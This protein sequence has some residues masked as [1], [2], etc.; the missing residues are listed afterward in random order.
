MAA[1][2]HL[3]SE[4]N[5]VKQMST[6]FL[7]LIFSTFTAL[8]ANTSLAQSPAA[9]TPTSP[10]T[11]QISTDPATQ[12]PPA[13]V[14]EEGK[15]PTGEEDTKPTR[16]FVSALVHNLGDDVKHIPRRNSLYWLGGGAAL[17]L[18]VHPE[19]RKINARLVN[20]SSDKLWVPG[21]IIG[22]TYLILGAAGATYI[23]GRS[24]DYHRTQHLGMDIIEASILS[25]GLV[26]GMK[27][28]AR[29]PRPTQVG[30]GTQSKT[31]SFPSGHAAITFAAATVFQQHMGYKAAIPTYLV[32]SYVA[33]SRLHDNR[34][35]ASDVLFG[36]A[37][38]IVVG[39]SVTWHGR[40]FY[41][42]P[43]L[44]PGG[45]GIQLMAVR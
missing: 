40:N 21:H 26:E 17:A 28:I 9:S 38:G 27:V 24:T 4:G 2:G 36:A 1:S 44:V 25:E 33:M 13:A 35:Y 8:F 10:D 16:G 34:H 18:A 32:A 39:R 7:I 45:A 5:A 30:G 19:D 31:Y 43:M 6:S 15:K 12:K 22:N 42:S 14:G 41:A 37:T 23:F 29:R 3:S 11:A 20:S